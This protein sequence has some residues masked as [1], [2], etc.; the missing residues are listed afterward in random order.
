[1]VTIYNIAY[2]QHGWY[3]AQGV[4]TT[5]TTHRAWTKRQT[6]GVTEQKT[7]RTDKT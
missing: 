7:K 5:T 4:D 6:N 2:A 1:M 3:T